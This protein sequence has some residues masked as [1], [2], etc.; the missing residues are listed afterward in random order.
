M[1][2]AFQRGDIVQLVDLDGERNSGFYLG[3]LGTVVKPNG[4]TN[5]N[6]AK[7]VAVDWG[8]SGVSN[9]GFHDLG[10]IL[11]G[12]TG[13]WVQ[14]SQIRLAATDGEVFE[15]DDLAGFWG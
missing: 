5:R 9:N 12:K 11:P 8:I 3:L 15:V 6:G 2:F 13:Y 7:C 14:E 10:G 4:W 1:A